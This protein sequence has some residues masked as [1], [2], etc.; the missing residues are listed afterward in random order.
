MTV[1][2][3]LAAYSSFHLRIKSMTKN[4]QFCIVQFQCASY[5]CEWRIDDIALILNE[6]IRFHVVSA[7]NDQIDLRLNLAII[8][9]I[10]LYIYYWGER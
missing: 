8:I 10:I 1:E 6:T 2:P 9:I 5:I 3:A 4:T 7:P